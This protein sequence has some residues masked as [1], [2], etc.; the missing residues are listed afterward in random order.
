LL[1]FLAVAQD[2]PL[3]TT[4][5]DADE[6]IENTANHFAQP[7]DGS[8]TDYTRT[9]W[10]EAGLDGYENGLPVSGEFTSQTGSGTVF[11]LQ[12]YGMNGV[13]SN[14]ALRLFDGATG[15]L[16]LVTPEY[17]SSLA[18]LAFTASGS[19]ADTARPLTI[20]FTDGSTLNTTFSAPDWVTDN[21]STAISGLGR[22]VVSGAG[23]QYDS[24]A[25]NSDESFGMTETDINLSGYTNKLVQSLTFTGASDFTTYTTTSVMA[26]SAQAVPE[27]TATALSAAGVIV[28]VAI[29]RRRMARA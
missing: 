5:Y 17:L 6:V 28:L 14:N 3:A 24:G 26:I 4:G 18:I 19:G 21:S 16:T 11:Q 7:V 25:A 29:S 15:M 27:P 1:P 9:A 13:Q 8:L 23:F 12:P 20:T 2:T 10:F 22:S